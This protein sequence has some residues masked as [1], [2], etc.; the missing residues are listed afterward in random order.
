M[1]DNTPTT[2]PAPILSAT[3]LTALFSKIDR[4][5]SAAKLSD[6]FRVSGVDEASASLSL[7][8]TLRRIILADTTE[9]P[10]TGE[11][12]QTILQAALDRLTA[13]LDTGAFTG[14]LV[15]LVGMSGQQV[16]TLATS[17]IGVRY[18]IANFVPFAI[19]GATDVYARHNQDGSLTRFD[20]ATGTMLI[21]TEYLGDRSQLFAARL[22]SGNASQIAITGNQSFL[23]D[24]RSRRGADGNSV[25]TQLTADSPNR[26]VGR[27]T[28][29]ADN[30]DGEIVA[31]GTGN[32]RLY[33]GGGDDNIRGGAGDDYIEGGLG[34][35]YIQGGIGSDTLIGGLGDDEVEGGLGNDIIRAGVGDDVIA[36]GKGDDRLDGGDG[37]DT[38]VFDANDGNDVILDSDGFGEVM[39]AGA[40]LTGS[41]TASGGK[42]VS[43]DGKITYSFA[44]DIEEGGVLTITTEGG[45]IKI[46]DFR[47]GMLGIKLGDGSPGALFA[48][49]DPLIDL[50]GGTEGNNGN[51]LRGRYDTVYPQWPV[52]DGYSG[53]NDSGD[54][55]VAPPKGDGSKKVV[56]ENV[57]DDFITSPDAALP[58]V[59]GATYASASAAWR[60]TPDADIANTTITPKPETVIGVTAADITAAVM[61][62][63]DDISDAHLGGDSIAQHVTR[64]DAMLTA[65]PDHLAKLGKQTASLDSTQT[66]PRIGG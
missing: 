64:D 17:Q 55:E 16:A 42:Y 52:N 14:S 61:D 65:T 49:A 41:A 54:G 21:S 26:P 30:T 44:G 5:F 40:A 62:F 9:I 56:E 1:P 43:A 66:A 10:T 8:N 3:V 48:P 51:P 58:L 37:F 6:L 24:D 57:L 4:N 11:D 23:I 13:A 50:P 31:G 36:G 33:G 63:H 46:R 39:Y 45:R 25:R 38:Y 32:D 19:I 7:F 59:S 20:P 22:A 27:V 60:E 29:G 15:S 18:S 2:P 35:D 28:F 53:G 12:A 34:N 47:N